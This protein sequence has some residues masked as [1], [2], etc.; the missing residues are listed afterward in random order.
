[1]FFFFY[2]Y[3]LLTKYLF[4]LRTTLLMTNSHCHHCTPSPSPEQMQAQDT[5]VSQVL[6]LL[7]CVKTEL[8]QTLKQ[9]LE[10]VGRCQ[11]VGVGLGLSL[12]AVP[13]S[14]NLVS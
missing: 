13:L 1:M 7:V 10:F 12:C 9:R 5:S 4:A 8:Q 2:L 11:N 3:F 14:R 6:E